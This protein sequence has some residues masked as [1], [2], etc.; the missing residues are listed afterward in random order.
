[1]ER[2]HIF[3]TNDLH[4]HLE[5][6]P[7]IRRFLI[8]HQEKLRQKEI[9][10]LTIDLGDFIDRVHPFTDATFGQGNIDLMNT[11]NFDA[12]TIGNNEGLG[13]PHDRLDHLYDGAEF[14]VLLGNFFDRKSGERP[15]WASP[16]K[17]LTTRGGTRIGLLGLT[18]S[19]PLTHHA[20]GWDVVPPDDVLP[21]LL[22]EL[23]GKTDILILLSHLGL[24]E[25]KRLAREYPEFDVILGSHTHHLL[26]EGLVVGKTLLTGAGR[27]GE[28]I[29]EVRL[30]VTPEHQIIEKKA[31]TV[32][33]ESLP[34]RQEDAAEIVGYL[35]KGRHI[36][37]ADEQA[38]LCQPLELGR[39]D[40]RSL[41]TQALYAITETAGAPVG[42]LSTGL[43][44]TELPQGSVNMAQLH[45]CLPHP[46][47]LIRVTLKG[48]DVIRLVR[49]MEKNRGFL[50]HFS[51]TGMGFRGKIFGDICYYQLAYDQTTGT[52]Y[53]CGQPVDKAKEYQLVTVD[54]F[55]FIPFFPTIELAGDVE[56]VS[57][58]F[59]REILGAYLGRHCPLRVNN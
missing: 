21:Q 37:E 58:G 48:T 39:N 12:V 44:L 59:L 35:D 31:V 41:V 30:T 27:F 56:V 38:F 47:H 10:T 25:D 24:P 20:L 46:M 43:F 3:H 14:D 22:Q 7:K 50:K 13:L 53:W 18:A 42:I 51:V 36:L 52:V 19:F 16:Y 9:A 49:E 29:G 33:V 54:H 1:M 57:A 28:Y 55:M 23:S 17:I 26:P 11:V 34:E 6:W 4:S 2:I 40:D 5:H 45:R 8:A 15:D 32:A